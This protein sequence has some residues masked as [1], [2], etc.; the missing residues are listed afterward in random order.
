MSYNPRTLQDLGAYW[1]GKGGVNLGVV[2]DTGHTVGYHLGRDRIYGPGGQGDDDYSVKHRRDMAGL[3]GA[4]SAIDLGRLNGEL[5][6]LYAFQPLARVHVEGRRGHPRDHLFP[7]RAEGA[8]V[9]RDRRQDTHGA[10]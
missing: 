9:V 7:G 3:S 8:A 10:R 4:A 2:G 6:E 1:T 5:T